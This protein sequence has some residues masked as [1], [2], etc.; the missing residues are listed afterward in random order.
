MLP[1]DTRIDEAVAVVV[2]EETHGV[3]GGVGPCGQNDR[4]CAPTGMGICM[5][6][7]AAIGEAIG[8]VRWS[9]RRSV[10][11]GAELCTRLD[12]GHAH[13]GAVKVGAHGKREVVDKGLGRAVHVVHR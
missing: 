12:A 3:G 13:A 5:A 8:A 11:G 2:M 4:R 9:K 1:A 10:H 6:I 7:G